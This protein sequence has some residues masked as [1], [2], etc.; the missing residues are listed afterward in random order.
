[1]GSST[2]KGIRNLL[3]QEAVQ[4]GSEVL[5][6]SIGCVGLRG[7]QKP[8]RAIPKEKMGTSHSEQQSHSLNGGKSDSCVFSTPNPPAEVMGAAFLIL[9]P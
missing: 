5:G 7:P 9:V 4:T 1:M 3:E 6:G 8:V 2:Q